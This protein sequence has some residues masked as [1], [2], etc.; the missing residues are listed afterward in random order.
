MTELALLGGKPALSQPLTAYPSIQDKEINAV[1]D[2]MKSGV[3]SGFFGSPG[4]KFMG[5]EQVQALEKEWSALY[6]AKRS[7][8]VNSAT[9]G[10]HAA[11][12]AIGISPGDEVIVPPVTMSATVIAPLL[13]GGIPVFADIDPDTFCL[14]PQK[15]REQITPKTRA[16]I[17]VNLFGNPAPLEELRQIADEHGLKLIED[18]AQAPLGRLAD[19][20]CGLWG[21]IGI[22]SLNYHKHIH[23]GEGGICVTQDDNLAD[24]MALIRN[25][26]ENVA[27]DYGC[28]DLVNCFGLNLRMTELSAA[29]ARTQLS[30]IEAHVQY[31]ER[32]AKRLSAA[33]RHL[34][35]WTVPE[36]REDTRHNYYMWT[37]R[38]DESR[39]GVP[40]DVLS[41]ALLAEGF[42]NETGYIEPIYM[43]PLFQKRIAMGRDGF[44]FTLTDRQYT[45]GLCPVAERLYENE[46]IQFQPPNYSVSDE[47]IDDLIAAV[48][49]VYDNL[50]QLKDV[51]L[52]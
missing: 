50:D 49:K 38:Y 24:R 39:T 27:L 10:L 11:I 28:D 19:R 8:S 43:L 21:D 41:K 44:P 36:E 12:G 23:S 26:G 51:K 4:P 22:F 46:I 18:N 15:V 34:P 16:I 29:V 48:L 42:E 35:G 30:D 1:M 6:G 20:Y 45:K 14:D 25:H 9:S 52:P 2:V 7:I 47:Q 5:G 32:I 3:L 17:V 33:T 13:Y 40:R 31:R 37:V